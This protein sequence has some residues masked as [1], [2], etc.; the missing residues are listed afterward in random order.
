MSKIYESPDGGKTVYVRDTD[1]PDKERE[2]LFDY[3]LMDAEIQAQSPY[4]DGWTQEMYREY[5]MDRRQQ[6]QMP[7]VEE[8]LWPAW[9]KMN[10]TE[11]AMERYGSWKAMKDDGWDLTDDG[12]WINDGSTK[13]LNKE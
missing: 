4:N 13:V 8:E 12:F 6:L 9:I 10:L 7:Q 3:K 11:E 5:A 2:L 1:T